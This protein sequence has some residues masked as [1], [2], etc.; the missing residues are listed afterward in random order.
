MSKYTLKKR[1]QIRDKIE[2]LCE[3]YE[4]SIMLNMGINTGA[5]HFSPSPEH[6]NKEFIVYCKNEVG[7]T[8]RNTFDLVSLVKY[9]RIKDIIDEQI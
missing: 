3:K 4:L 1:R 8:D 9:N 6:G 7:V 2:E 5:K